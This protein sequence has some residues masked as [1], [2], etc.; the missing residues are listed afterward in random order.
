[1]KRRDDLDSFYSILSDLERRIGGRRRLGECDGR[2]NWPERGVYFF[3]EPGEFRTGETDTQRV[4]RVGTHAL[5]LQSKTTLWNRLSQHRGTLNPKGGNHRGSIFRLLIGEALMNRDQSSIVETWG[6]NSSAPRAVR[7]A[8][9]PHEVSV[10][11]YIGS[12]QLLYLNVPDPAG[13]DSARGI[14]ERNAIA[15]LSGYRDLSTDQPSLDWLGRYSGRP[16][17]RKS[18]LWNNRHVDENYNPSFLRLLKDLVRETGI[19]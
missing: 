15:L 13:G 7:L 17:V 2:M 3:F 16:L 19:S 12:M 1:M 11:D 18:G 10:S 9:R 4:V 5:T 14:V 6:K 8:E